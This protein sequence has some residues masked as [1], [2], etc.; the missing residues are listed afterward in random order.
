MSEQRDYDKYLKGEIRVDG[1]QSEWL[2]K[3]LADRA[4]L[5]IHQEPK[6]KPSKVH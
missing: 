2:K 4:A 6:P 5:G 1:F 3:T